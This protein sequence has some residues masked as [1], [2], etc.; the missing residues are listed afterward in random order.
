MRNQNSFISPLDKQQEVVLTL[1]VLMHFCVM[2]L[3]C[4][5]RKEECENSLGSITLGFKPFL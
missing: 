4:V 3:Q 1:V 5:L 2:S